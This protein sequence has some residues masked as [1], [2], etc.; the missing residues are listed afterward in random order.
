MMNAIKTV[1]QNDEGIRAVYM[2][3]S[4]TNPRAPK[5]IFQDYDI[6]YVVT[7]LAPYLTNPQWIDI[8]GKRLMIQEPDKLDKQIGIPVNLNSYGYLMLF[9]D[10]NRIDLRLQTIEEMLHT[11]K[12][13]SLTVP[14]LDKDH[15]LPTIPPSSDKDY[16]VRQPTEADYYACTNNFWWCLQNVAKG[17]WREEM[18]YAKQMFELVIRPCLDQM[19]AWW[20]GC[21]HDFQVAPGKMGK[22]FSTYLP[23]DYWQL[24]KA[25]YSGSS[26][27]EFWD[28]IF[29]ACKLF[30]LLALHVA[31]QLGFTYKKE[32]ETAMLHFLHAVKELPAD[33]KTIF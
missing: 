22:Y 27:Q 15:I 32:E 33:A 1:A 6:V 4:R 9:Q 10:G 14:V 3:G 20:I 7:D 29:T 24:Y 13:D 30:R 17:I 23:S 11:Y 5:D 16:H 31:T 19:V 28:S 12:A 18:P 21:R 25:T 8:F 26:N 2:N